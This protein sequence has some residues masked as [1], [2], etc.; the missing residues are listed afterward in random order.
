MEERNQPVGHL[1]I[2]GLRGTEPFLAKVDSYIRE[3][4]GQEKSTLIKASCPRFGTGEG[5]AALGETVRGYDLFIYCD[6]FN[7]GETYKMYGMTVPMS[8]DDHYA[9][10]KR[11]IGAA[12][13]KQR[14]TTVIMPMLYE[15]R[16]H[17]RT[18]RESL[19]CAS[20]LQ[21]L[22]GLG[23][24]NIITCDAHDANVANAIPG[25]GFENLNPAY[26]YLKAVRRV[27]PDVDF[28]ADDTVIISPDEGAMS[29]CM[30]YTSALNIDLGMF[31][32]RR[33][34]SR[35][36]DGRNPIVAHEYLG[37]DLTDKNAIVVDDMI[38]SGDSVIDICEQLKSRG[39][40]RILVFSA[41]GL[42]NAG[43]ER[44]D[45]AYEQGLFDK[46]FTTNLIYQNPE[47]LH[48]E[49][50]C[51]VEMAKLIA[52]VIDTLNCDRSISA[53]LDPID[54]INRLLDRK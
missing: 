15:G 8:P 46:I 19:D 47:L 48:R 54:R 23:V 3:W 51:S 18:G 26:Q 13:G 21:E 43:L 30:Y 7:Y 33:D 50:Y 28:R 5:K 41:F 1:G 37:N 52:Y 17:R 6:P 22:V 49:W 44:M 38:S 9:D 24:N 32:K 12:G 20:M 2:I 16:Q 45:R 29:R 40:K 4:R 39:V 14:R 35:V 11:V 53:L 27:L 10:L 25:H 31:Y 36:V 42:F 34:Y